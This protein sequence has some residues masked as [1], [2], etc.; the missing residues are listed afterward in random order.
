MGH[1]QRALDLEQIGGEGFVA[2][3]MHGLG[4]AGD[5]GHEVVECRHGTGE[6]CTLVVHRR[7]LSE[8]IVQENRQM[9]VRPWHLGPE[10]HL[11]P[12]RHVGPERR[13]RPRRGVDK[14]TL[15]GGSQYVSPGWVA[16]PSAQNG[17]ALHAPESSKRQK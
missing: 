17:S 11:G 3:A 6:H 16:G 7:S 13:R 10:P 15:G 1:A 4:H 5:P 14:A 8:G 12:E 9:R 2:G